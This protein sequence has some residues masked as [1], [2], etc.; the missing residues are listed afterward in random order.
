MLNQQAPLE[1]NRPWG[2][3]TLLL[4]FPA[5]MIPLGFVDVDLVLFI[6]EYQVKRFGRLMGRSI[7]N[8]GI[9]GASDPAIIY[10]LLIAA[11][12]FA[13]SRKR[14]NPAFHQYRP[15]LGF[16]LFS[17]LFTG[18]GLV[19]SLKWIIG[20]ARPNVVLKGDIRLPYTD[21]YEFGPQFISDGVFYGSFPSGHT[22]TV[23]LMITV[24]YL[25][26]GDR[27]NPIKTRLSGWL[28][29]LVVLLYTSVMIVGRSM[30]YDHWITDSVG[31]TLLSWISIHIIYYYVLKVPEQNR[32]VDSHNTYAPI[33]R[34][35]EISLLWRV[36]MLTI[37]MM[38]IIIGFRSIIIQ[39]T[40]W[41]V[42]LAIPGIVLVYK[43]TIS[44]IQLQR[45]SMSYFHSE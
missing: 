4:L 28:W 13:Y 41:L 14:A 34:Y 10:Q 8:G 20:R 24:A 16:A 30:T 5:I 7:I 6:H 39:R 35:W 12:Y 44:V 32:Y 38:S 23:F 15:F 26:A 40:P 11:F 9:P 18:L 3:I 42:I 43:F 36:F 19:H 33:P 21:W 25:L 2:L 45:K 27:T 1:K 31:I 22:A 29:G 37:G 17:C